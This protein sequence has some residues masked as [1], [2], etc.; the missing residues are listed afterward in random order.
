MATQ[1]GLF[2]MRRFEALSNTIFGVAM[3]LLAYGIP[4]ERLM[5]AAPN[6][7]TILHAY[8]SQL[9]ALLLGFLVAG[10][11]WFSHQRRLVYA[12]EANRLAV[13]INLLF[14]L[15]IILL[16]VTT[17]LYGTYSDAADVIALY[18]FHLSLISALN[19]VLWFMAA[20]PR[21]DWP[22]IGGSAFSTLI[23][24]VAS[25]VS[26]FAPHLAKFLW[27]FAFIA[28]IVAAFLERRGQVRA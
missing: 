15:S 9:L 1:T 24:L 22:V 27:L 18:S 25:I 13:L 7:E 17:G 8:R 19:V 14:L 6:W 23:F 26:L 16:P 28:P 2:E 3:T 11:F 4:K 10:M 12:P 20:A 21:R 5:D